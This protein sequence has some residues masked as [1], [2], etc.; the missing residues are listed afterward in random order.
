MYRYCCIK[1]EDIE[2]TNSFKFEIYQMLPE[3]FQL[4]LLIVVIFCQVQLISDFKPA[5]KL[6]LKSEALFL[7]V[8]FPGG[9]SCSHCVV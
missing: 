4:D 3:L 8:K 5:G 9:K 7:R 2:V 6:R 1:I